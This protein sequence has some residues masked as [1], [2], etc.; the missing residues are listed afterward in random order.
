VGVRGRVGWVS[1]R[2]R[3]VG[4]S[5]G[6][7]ETRDGLGRVS[8]PG[9]AG[10]SQGPRRSATKG[11]ARRSWACAAMISQFQRSPA[12]GV[13]IF[14]VVQPR[15]CLNSRMV[16]S[17]SKRRRNVPV[18]GNAGDGDPLAGSVVAHRLEGLVDEPEPGD[19]DSLDPGNTYYNYS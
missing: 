4:R 6:C 19:W 1:V 3:A 2:G 14:G 7:F 11:R 15:A 5:G 13:R 18:T 12:W 8:L 10:R 9:W 16:C 17:R